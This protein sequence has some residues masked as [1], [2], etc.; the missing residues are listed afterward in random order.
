LL[1]KWE[2]DDLKSFLQ[3]LEAF[4]SSM[5]GYY[6]N[7]GGKFDPQHPRWANFADILLAARVYE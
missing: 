7:M 1:Q 3:A 5:E 2:N 4:A 6:S